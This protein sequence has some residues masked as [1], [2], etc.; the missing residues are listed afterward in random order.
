MGVAALHGDCK[1][2]LIPY[3]QAGVMASATSYRSSPWLLHPATC[4]DD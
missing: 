3:E 4:W 2:G 1:H